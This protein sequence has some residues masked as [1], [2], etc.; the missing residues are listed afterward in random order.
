VEDLLPLSEA[1]GRFIV[2]EAGDEPGSMVAV[3]AGP[4]EIREIL[5]DVEGVVIANH[6]APKQV[7]ISGARPAL[8]R[9]TERLKDHGVQVR[10]VRVAC[11]FHSPI[12]AP[13]QKKLAQLL[14]SLELR[15]PSV[16][17]F[18]NTTADA[19][20][21]DPKAIAAQLVEHLV[22]P[23]RFVEEIEA[24][25]AAGARIF[26]EV[27]PRNVLRALADQILGDRPH[28]A[29]ATDQPG[30]SATAQLL[31]VLGR[32]A[33]EGV[34]VKL[35]RF[36]EGTPVSQ[37]D[38]NNLRE[39]TDCEEAPGVWLVNG[40]RA[41]P[42][43]DGSKGSQLPQE[44]RPATPAASELW[45]SGLTEELTQTAAARARAE[46][47]SPPPAS[48]AA[49]PTGVALEATAA[50]P[51][52]ASD[53][54]GA[55][56]VMSQFQQ[57]M[58]RFLETQQNIMLA[59]LR[60][61]QGGAGAPTGTVE[62]RAPTPASYPPTL[63]QAPRAP[64]ASQ[65]APAA[66]QAATTGAPQAADDKPREAD[67]VTPTE[68]QL[69]LNEE[70]LTSRLVRLVSERTGYPP[71]MLDLDLDLEADLGIDSIK[72]VEIL[73]NYQRLYTLADRPVSEADMEKLTTI[74]TLRGIV[75]WV[76]DYVH[77]PVGTSADDASSPSR[78][79]EGE[80]GDRGAEESAAE[81][82]RE[83]SIQ[84]YTLGPIETPIVNIQAGR[85]DL[86]GLVVLTDDERGTAQALADQL[87]A[88]GNEV[89]LIQAGDKTLETAPGHYTAD[90]ISPDGVA[91]VLELIRQRQGSIAALAHLPGEGACVL[92]SRAFSIWRRG[93]D[94]ISTGRPE[95]AE[96]AYWRPPLWVEPSPVTTPLLKR[97]FR[98]VTAAWLA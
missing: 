69:S 25:Y 56:Q 45:G 39:E 7:L 85:L 63:G 65:V 90:L 47:P 35:D 14:D 6:N 50:Q 98:P 81:S 80:E 22:R 49:E 51:A 54:G 92:R 64:A 27:G 15:E 84:R 12:V 23:V 93:C 32:L 18:S 26:L 94:R 38:V 28:L 1:R 78:N 40:G 41:F 75:G 9:A 24:M 16:A 10:S 8:E 71:E 68:V 77:T 59:Y 31:H 76:T 11:A 44:K 96:P 83:S 36:F 91:E 86:G 13:A 62:H 72:R 95:R 29:L 53:S 5:A 87:A 61:Q 74:R 43:G 67:A 20:P 21:R 3:E 34:P 42:S 30:R 46:A 19:Y 66:P 97:P 79:G 33:T 88:R 2:E 52:A 58:Q 89:A 57:L 37:L 82:V 17:V 55:T 70:E 73:G 4:E 60:N 48:S